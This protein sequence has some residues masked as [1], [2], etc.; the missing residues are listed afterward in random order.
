[1]I[2]PMNVFSYG[3]LMIPSV[4]IAVTGKRFRTLRARLKDY[5]RFKVKEESYPGI[6]HRPG[7]ST[8]GIVHCDVDELSLKLL[9][10]F[11]GEIYVRISVRVEADQKGPLIA[12][13]YT[14]SPHHL[15]LL[16]SKPWDFE[17]FKKKHVQE[18]LKSF[19]GFSA[20]VNSR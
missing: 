9:D 14:L 2:P 19:K 5:A 6:A 20:L 11:E 17:E 1:M 3:S 16:S 7:A 8:D 10:K 18:F 13:T 15:H 12:E 4:M